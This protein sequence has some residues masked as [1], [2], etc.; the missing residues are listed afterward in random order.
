MCNASCFGILFKHSADY[1]FWNILFGRTYCRLVQWLYCCCCLG[2]ANKEAE[3]GLATA[4]V[5]AV[6]WW[7]EERQ[8]VDVGNLV[9]T[10]V[11][12]S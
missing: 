11:G 12:C 6:L 7:L 2:T 10:I 1:C 8:L 3:A 4:D 5:L 9:K